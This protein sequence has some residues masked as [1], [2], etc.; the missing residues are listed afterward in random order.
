MA[1]SPSEPGTLNVSDE[2]SDTEKTS[3]AAAPSASA[4][5]AVTGVA[6]LFLT[7]AGRLGG[8]GL[9]TMRAGMTAWQWLALVLL[10]AAFVYG[11]GYRALHRRYAPF[12]VERAG[13]LGPASSRLRC[14]LAPLWAMALVGERSRLVVRAWA[15][16]WAIVVAVVLVRSLPEPWRGIV[17]FAVAGALFWGFVALLLE[18]WGSLSSGSSDRVSP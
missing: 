6:A 17:D 1:I 18:A 11:E 5:W 10:T 16:A 15:G 14:V 8:R 4:W 3:S 9:E 7:A 12:V 2:R 13:R